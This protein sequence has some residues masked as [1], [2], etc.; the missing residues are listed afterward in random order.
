MRS[1]KANL[2][3]EMVISVHFMSGAIQNT[4]KPDKLMDI[5]FKNKKIILNTCKSS[6]SLFSKVWQMLFL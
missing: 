6:V 4:Q 1:D 5:T 2:F 3:K